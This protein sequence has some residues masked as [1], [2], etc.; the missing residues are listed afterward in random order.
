MQYWYLQRRDDGQNGWNE[1]WDTY[2][3][4]GCALIKT[5]IIKPAFIKERLDEE[6]VNDSNVQE[7]ECSETEK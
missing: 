3:H 7:A 4:A 6:K 5:S 2:I 1:F